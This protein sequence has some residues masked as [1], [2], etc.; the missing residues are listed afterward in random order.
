MAAAARVKP[1]GA[2]RRGASRTTPTEPIKLTFGQPGD[3]VNRPVVRRCWRARRAR[4]R[5]A[6][7]A[8]RRR[9]APTTIAEAQAAKAATARA[10][11]ARQGGAH[12]RR[13]QAPSVR[14]AERV[15]SVVRQR[16]QRRRVHA[17]RADIAVLRRPHVLDARG[18]Y[19]AKA[20]K[21]VE[22]ATA[23][24][25]PRRSGR[26]DLHAVG[27]WRDAT[28]VAF[29]GVGGDTAPDGAVELP[30]A[31]GLCRRR[32]SRP[33]AR[34][35]CLRRGRS[36][37]DFTLESGTGTSP[38]IEDALHGGDGA[39]P[40]RQPGLPAHDAGPA[41]STRGRRA[42]YARRGG[43]YALSYDDLSS[44]RTTPTRSTACRRKSCST[45]RSCAR[46][47]SS[48]STASRGRRSTT[49]DTVPYFLLPSLGSG[50]TLRALSEL[51]VPRSAQPAAVGGVA[52]DPEPDVPRHGDLLRRRQGGRPPRGSRTSQD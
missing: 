3:P 5:R 46:T 37:E 6:A 51:A 52:L 8:R 35:G 33:R 36:Y 29:Y 11:R 23:V 47:G 1:D 28:Q 13:R 21:L 32:R 40:R 43:L 10:L 19:S 48:R 22:L 39:G 17:R 24:A 50:S 4:R 31:A 30:D 41:A 44:I 7:G 49:S 20:Y 34:A 18:L 16:V 26:V 38:S 27:G 2:G 9:R 45:C 12:R 15:L 14:D 42:G 25:R